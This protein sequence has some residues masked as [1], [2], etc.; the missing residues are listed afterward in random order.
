ML[1]QIKWFDVSLS[2]LYI[3]ATANACS[4]CQVISQI[5][6]LHVLY[7]SSIYYYYYFFLIT[8]KKSSPYFPPHVH[9]FPYHQ[10]SSGEHADV[11]GF[12]VKG[13]GPRGRLGLCRS[14][15]LRRDCSS[16]HFSL[17][18]VQ[19]SVLLYILSYFWAIIEAIVL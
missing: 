18:L 12:N 19:W 14:S 17:H 15:P 2:S 9:R 11:T 10:K 1:A 4:L 8:I 6:Q 5:Q 3:A 13:S 16:E 7:T